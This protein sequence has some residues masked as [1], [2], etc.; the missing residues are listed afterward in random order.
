[1]VGA[2]CGFIG[3]GQ[4]GLPMARRLLHAGNT[5]TIYNRSKAPVEILS[6]EGAA[7]AATAEELG[8]KSDVVL[9]SLPDATSVKDVLFGSHGAINAMHDGAVIIDTSTIGPTFARQLA[10]RAQEKRVHM[11]DAPVSGGPDGASNGT[12]SIMVG[13]EKSIFENCRPIL[14]V[15][16][17]RIFYMGDIGAGQA[18]KLANQLLVGIHVL[19][20]SEALLFAASQGLD[21]K[22]VIDVIQ[23]SSGNSTQFQRTAPQ[24]IS[25]SF[26]NGFQTHLMHKDLGLVLETGCNNNMPLLLTG[27][28][29]ELV[30]ANL[31]LGNHRMN[32]ASIIRVMEKLTGI[33]LRIRT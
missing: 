2:C 31:R 5:L 15:L 1:M 22:K 3:L 21:L 32:T 11:L 6:K 29:R 16:G 33:D 13:G 14:D 30:T 17:Q 10:E 24:M 18:M 9:L 8:A 12:L 28:T 20:A 26:K 25:G 23:A 4:M 19:A 7:P 27:I